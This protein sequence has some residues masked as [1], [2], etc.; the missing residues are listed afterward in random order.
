MRSLS[1]LLIVDVQNDFCPGGLLPVPEG[2]RVVP[3][4][5]RY[6]E[7]FREKKLPIIA[8]RD[9]HP[10]ITSHFRDF[11]GI[12][13]VHCV[14]G[15]KGARFHRDLALPDDAIVISKGQDPAQDAYSAF[16][17]TTES[18]VSFPELLK[19][20][21]IT[22]LFVGGLATDYC[23]KESVLDGL[24]HGL[25]VTLL[26]DAVRGVDLTPG[27]SAR[28]IENMVVA[29]AVRMNFSRLQADPPS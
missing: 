3:L 19:E 17:A 13:P 4:L 27:D 16:Q 14:Q 29:G 5:N 2:D 28:A 20:L 24:R 12:W 8:S 25:A 18:G 15:S 11:G 6:M 9:W 10:A 7:L 1:A 23:I 22:R 26:E 21:G